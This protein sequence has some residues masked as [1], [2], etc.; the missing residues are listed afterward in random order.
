MSPVYISKH[1][2]YK[3]PG[4]GIEKGESIEEALKREIKEEVGCDITIEEPLGV[5][6]EYRNST[7]LLTLSYSYLCRVK[8]KIS[9]PKYDKGEIEDGFKSVWKS[10]DEALEI[11]EKHY[12]SKPYQAKF[13]VTREKAF[14]E[15]C[16]R[17]LQK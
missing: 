16:K 14:L 4:G 13:I 10:I 5:I 15:E 11:L 3:L 6:V 8:G 7:N 12:P 2:F 1:N 9:N 17:I